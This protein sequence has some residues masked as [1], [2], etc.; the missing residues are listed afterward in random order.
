MVEQTPRA[1]AKGWRSHNH[2]FF[3]SLDSSYTFSL[4]THYLL[5]PPGLP[6]QMG[7]FRFL[8]RRLHD[9]AQ[10]ISYLAKRSFEISWQAFSPSDYDRDAKQFYDELDHVARSVLQQNIFSPRFCLHRSG[11]SQVGLRGLALIR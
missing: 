7:R 1:C 9:V 10:L 5:T 11:A 2:R 8:R 3:L 4:E 6:G